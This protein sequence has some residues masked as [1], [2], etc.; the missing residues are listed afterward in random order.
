[1]VCVLMTSSHLRISYVHR[2]L[3]DWR[4]H[5]SDTQNWGPVYTRFSTEFVYGFL[6]IKDRVCVE[7]CEVFGIDYLTVKVLYVF[8]EIE[9]ANFNP[10]IIE[11]RHWNFCYKKAC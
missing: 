11:F 5:N 6:H 7:S 3:V 10:C 4:A 2:L 1:M 9:R 8:S